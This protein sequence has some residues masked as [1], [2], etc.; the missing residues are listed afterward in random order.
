MMK[1]WWQNKNPREQLLI[2]IMLA[3]VLVAVYWYGAVVPLN[4]AIEKQGRENHTL[5]RNLKAMDSSAQNIGLTK[6]KKLTVSVDKV[7]N[8]SA[9]R[10]GLNIQLQPSQQAW[11]VSLTETELS[12]FIA[13]LEYLKKNEGIYPAELKL[14]A[15]ANNRVKVEKLVL[16]QAGFSD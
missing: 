13:W 4:D 9:Q 1:S 3:A 2:K 7:I 12:P 15:Q 14:T 10:A 16:K 11:T 8:E 5:S 6:A